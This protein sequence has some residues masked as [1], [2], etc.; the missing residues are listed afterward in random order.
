MCKA[1]C[2]THQ[3]KVISATGTH[4]HGPHM[5]NKTQEMPPGHSPNSLLNDIFG[6][7]SSNSEIPHANQQPV[8]M[9]NFQFLPHPANQSQA[10]AMI[11]NMP[12]AQNLHS[13]ASLQLP[14]S[15]N[16]CISNTA[17]ITFKHESL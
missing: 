15:P 1:R 5:N 17:A 12:S 10:P 7:S 14:Q 11:Q 6:N 3:G 16:E 13:R 4:N 8:V 2:I 9:P